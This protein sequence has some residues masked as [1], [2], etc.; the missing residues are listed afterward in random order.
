MQPKGG[1]VLAPVPEWISASE[2]YRNMVEATGRWFAET[3]EEAAW[4]ACEHPDG[5]MVYVDVPAG[6]AESFR[7]SSIAERG[8][9]GSKNMPESP[10]A[11]SARPHAEFFVS[12]EVADMARPLS[13]TGEIGEDAP[14]A[15][16]CFGR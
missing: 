16:P 2:A 3:E 1:A 9:S 15:G 11:W 7:V 4:Y 6:L 10:A 5:E 12:R 14:E 8:G 13:L